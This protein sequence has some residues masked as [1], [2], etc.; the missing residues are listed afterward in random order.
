MDTLSAFIWICVAFARH[1][2]A[3][4]SQKY[5]HVFL[6]GRV[7]FENLLPKTY[8]GNCVLACEAVREASQLFASY[9]TAADACSEGAWPDRRKFEETIASIAVDVRRAIIRCDAGHIRE[10][11]EAMYHCANHRFNVGGGKFSM[12]HMG[13]SSLFDLATY[14]VDFGGILAKAA[15]VRLP[16][17]QADGMSLILPKSSED[18]LEYC[19]WLEDDSMQHLMRNPFW[20]ELFTPVT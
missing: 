17:N 20:N 1:D 14:S 12:D 10:H 8:I 4:D 16:D 15:A 13:I 2:G 9:T 6:N 5:L 3:Q 19:L 18:S 11:I 7:R